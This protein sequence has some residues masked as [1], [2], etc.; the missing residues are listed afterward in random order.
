MTVDNNDSEHQEYVAALIE[1]R[2][3]RQG[4]LFKLVDDPRLTRLGRKLRRLSIDEFPQLWN[5]LCG[6][7]SLVGPRPDVERAVVL[8]D[9]A[10]WGRLRVKPGMTGL[11]QVGGRSNLDFHQMV[12]LDT[13]YWERWSLIE[14]LRILLKTPAVVLSRKGAA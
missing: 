7:M 4:D 6:D 12:E 2:A 8:Y 13:E 1:G 14:E 11:W 5:V 10:A 3:D 9:A